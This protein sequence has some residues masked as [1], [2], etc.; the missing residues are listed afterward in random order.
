MFE[1]KL[2][3]KLHN[4]YVATYML[5]TLFIVLWMGRSKRKLVQATVFSIKYQV[6]CIH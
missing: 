3:T 4:Y 1:S 5:D 2:Y 6:Y